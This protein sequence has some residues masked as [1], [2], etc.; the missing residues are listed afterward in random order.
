MRILLIDVN[1]QKSSTGQIVYSVF[2]YLKKKGEEVAVCYGR[3]AASAQD[4][5]YKFGIDIE[6]TLHALLTRITGYTGCFSFFSTQRLIQYIRKFQPDVIH[7]HEVHAYF[8]NIKTLLKEIAKL[9]VPVVWT[10]HCEFMYT[11]KCGHAMDCNQWM[12][13][14]GNCPALKAYPKTWM[15]DRTKEMFISKKIAMEWLDSLQ[16]TV[17]SPWLMNRLKKS[18]LKERPIEVVFNGID[19]ETAF[20]LQDKTVSKLELDIDVER[21]M[22]LTV[23][24]NVIERSGEE[25][26][27]IAQRIP[28]VDFYMIGSGIRP[29]YYPSN[30]FLIDTIKERE[31]L[32]KYYAAA[33]VYLLC[34]AKETFSMPC[35]EALCCG[36]QVVGYEAGA[37]ESIFEAPYA[38]FTTYGDVEAIVK[39]LR[40][41]ID[42]PIDSMICAEYGKEYFSEDAMCHKFIDL[43]SKVCR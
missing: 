43:Y 34:S 3:G 27:K 41:A 16:L 36:T 4:G 10:F 12:Q 23:A 21:P 37:P 40:N 22:I 29:E 33:D 18:H 32:A 26:C 31:T 2:S 30:V 14:C 35:A 17:P 13:G 38:Q 20:R 6:T 15:F 42:Q 39:L 19:T 25:I 28:K 7:I 5:V 11:G 24:Q 9:G 1:Y 8:V